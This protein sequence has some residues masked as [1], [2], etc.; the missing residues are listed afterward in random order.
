MASITVAKNP[1][2]RTLALVAGLIAAAALLVINHVF[3]RWMPFTYDWLNDAVS[4]LLSFAA[5]Y[6][7]VIYLVEFFIYRKIKVIYKSI[8]S[9]KRSREK[10]YEKVNLDMDIIGDVNKE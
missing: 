2:P 4:F 9:E 3:Y 5:V 1:T 8:F 10:T 6:L 7:I